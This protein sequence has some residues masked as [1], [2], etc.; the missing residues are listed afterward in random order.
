ML[1]SPY[2]M[3]EEGYGKRVTI[4]AMTAPERSSLRLGDTEDGLGGESSDSSGCSDLIGIT[5]KKLDYLDHTVW[6]AWK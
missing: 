1:Y 6:S 3:S 2:G 5:G 4:I